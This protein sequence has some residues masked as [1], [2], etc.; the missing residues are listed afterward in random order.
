MFA[1][2]AYLAHP[3]SCAHALVARACPVSASV[4]RTS[5]PAVMPRTASADSAGMLQPRITRTS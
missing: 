5:A 2:P 3:S 1:N 4:E